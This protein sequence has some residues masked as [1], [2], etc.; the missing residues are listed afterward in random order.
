MNQ[1]PHCW[2][3]THLLIY[4]FIKYQLIVGYDWMVFEP[5]TII[6][7][8]NSELFINYMFNCLLYLIGFMIGIV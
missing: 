6:T 3:S 5:N 1:L 4:L 7:Q 2:Y 8:M